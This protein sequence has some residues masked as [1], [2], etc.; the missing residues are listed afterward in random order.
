MLFTPFSRP[1]LSSKICKALGL[2]KITEIIKAVA[3]AIE[4]IIAVYNF[5]I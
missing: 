2:S 1:E 4:P 3:E 5:G